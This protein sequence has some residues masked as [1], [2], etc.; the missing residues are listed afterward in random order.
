MDRDFFCLT[1]RTQVDSFT[2]LMNSLPLSKA[3]AFQAAA[4]A[5]AILVRV[6]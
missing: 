4:V 3:F 2:Q 6:G 1:P 5:I